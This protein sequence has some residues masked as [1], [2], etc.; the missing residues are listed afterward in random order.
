MA[1]STNTTR[2]RAPKVT[3]AQ[4]KTERSF[5]ERVMALPPEQRHLMLTLLDSFL[6]LPRAG[7]GRAVS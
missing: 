4:D 5:G 6:R 2:T 7:A 3:A 1:K